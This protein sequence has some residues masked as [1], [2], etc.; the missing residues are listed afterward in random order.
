MELLTRFREIG[1]REIGM[2]SKFN[3]GRRST[4]EQ[5]YVL[6]ALLLVM[7]LLII[8]AGTAATSLAFSIRR[9][10]E[11]ELVHRGVQYTRAIRAFSKTN[12]RYP[13]RVEELVH[14]NSLRYLR[15][16]YKDPITGKD[17]KLI[18]VNDIATMAQSI[19]N[20]TTAIT[21][22]GTNDGSSS[23]ADASSSPVSNATAADA[24]ADKATAQGGNTSA[25]NPTGAGNQTQ[26]QLSGGAICGVASTSR[27]RTIREFNRKN[28]YNEW[29]FFYLPNY[30]NGLPIKGP[31]SLTP[32][33]SLAQPSG[34]PGQPPVQPPGP[35]QQPPSPPQQ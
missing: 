20:G 34:L 1:F 32:P 4:G 8:A 30:D 19:P 27:S 33:T 9:D 6:L 29:F 15:K 35:A 5:G 2:K 24:G 17:F 26:N 25:A 7:A 18:Y 23:S 3:R 22:S 28:H 16:A 14:T 12:G 11:E 31:T 13:L 10:R 21:S